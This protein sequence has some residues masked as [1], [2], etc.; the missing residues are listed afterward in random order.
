M[1]PSRCAP[2]APQGQTTSPPTFL[3][4]LGLRAR[5]DLLGIF[6]LSFSPRSESGHHLG[7]QENGKKHQ[8]TY[9]HTDQLVR[10]PSF[11]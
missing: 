8:D 9:H 2:K 6:N 7:R 1:Q 10:H 3:K 4:A 11:P 5:Q